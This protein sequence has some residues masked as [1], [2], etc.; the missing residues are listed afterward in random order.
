MGCVSEIVLQG[1]PWARKFARSCSSR[2]PAHLDHEDLQAAGVLAYLR[3]ASRYDASAGASFRGYCATRIRGA[4]LDEVRR[5]DWAP[6]SVHRNHRR[7][8]RITSHLTGQLEREPTPRELADALGVDDDDFAAFQA[9]ARPRQIVSFDEVTENGQGEDKLPL[10]ERLADPE[11][12]RPDSR[13]RSA[14]DRRTLVQ[15]IERLTKTQATVIVLHYLQG[16]SLREVAR[17]LDVTP[18]RV[19][20][21]HHQALARLKL[22]WH[23]ATSGA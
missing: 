17:L 19:S 8:T 23:A 18:S 5:W 21:L 9:H 11:A 2:L 10:T 20:Q 12:E 3:A 14:E 22:S 15:C 13:V 6:R 16:V 1:L 7:I 4:V